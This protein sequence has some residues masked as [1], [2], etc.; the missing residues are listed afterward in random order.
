MSEYKI[1]TPKTKYPSNAMPANVL[2]AF[3][4]AFDA[5]GITA[6]AAQS[7]LNRVVGAMD[8]SP[9]EFFAEDMAKAEA[10]QAAAEK[11]LASAIQGKW[12]A[13]ADRHIEIAKNAVRLIG[14][15]R[16]EIEALE[17]SLWGIGEHD[18]LRS[19]RMI[20]IFHDIGE[21]FAQ[22]SQAPRIESTNRSM[23]MDASDTVASLKAEL[24]DLESDPEFLRAFT[25]P[26]NMRHGNVV[27]QRNRLIERLA[28]TRRAEAAGKRTEV[29]VRNETEL[30]KLEHDPEFMKVLN[31]PR[32]RQHKEVAARRER[33]LAKELKGP[34]DRGAEISVLNKFEADKENMTALADARHPRHAEV[35]AQR[36]RLIESVAAE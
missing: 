2:E 11:A 17:R 15:D 13:D 3:R 21:R 27:E 16:D 6:A 23:N 29:P 25:D 26:R 34:A 32:H 33:L 30:D 24:D 19:L 22:A 7:I 36:Q 20:E 14:I 9:Q 4:Q 5:E 12:G 18:T 35:S 10:D 28:T 8:A 1:E 31:D